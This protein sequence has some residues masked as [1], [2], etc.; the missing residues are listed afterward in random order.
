LGD[1]RI[2][3]SAYSTSPGNTANTN[4]KI[5]ITGITPTPLNVGTTERSHYDYDGA[6]TASGV[7][8]VIKRQ[9]DACP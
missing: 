6:S 7:N 8:I 9:A 4:N 2:T 1:G 5:C 3:L